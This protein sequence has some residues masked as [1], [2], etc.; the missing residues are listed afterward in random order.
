MCWPHWCR[1]PKVLNKAIFAAARNLRSDPDAYREVRDAGVAA[2]VAKEAAEG[3][4]ATHICIDPA[5]QKRT[6]P[7]EPFCSVHR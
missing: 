5:C 2:V 1:V 6:T 4:T 7:A 3:P